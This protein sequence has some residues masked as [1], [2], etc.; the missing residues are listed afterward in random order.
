MKLHLL[1]TA[2][3]LAGTTLGVFAQDNDK[4]RK[5]IGFIVG[6]QRSNLDYNQISTMNVSEEAK[7]NVGGS[8]FLNS[9]LIGHFIT[10]RTE[11]GFYSKGGTYRGG[12]V[13]E[14]NLSY[15]AAPALLLQTKIGFL[16][17]YAGPQM[18]FL[19]TAKSKTGNL[20]Q[21][22]KNSFKTTELSG[23]IGAEMNLPLRL[24]AG[25]RYNFGI[26]NI[27]EIAQGTS[28]PGMYMLYVGLRLRK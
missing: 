21:D 23:V 22:V 12:A 9:R 2:A 14:T 13:D 16:K 6:L 11:L 4:K 15:V 25:V 18:G 19:I 24:M 26:S 28:R 27:S 7:T 3:L 5:E 10:L 8:F 1:L 17:A 20:E